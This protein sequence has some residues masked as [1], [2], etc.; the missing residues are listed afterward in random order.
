[1]IRKYTKSHRR[2]M[3]PIPKTECFN[4]EGILGREFGMVLTQ[5]GVG[6]LK[7]IV[8]IHCAWLCC[9]VLV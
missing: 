6:D 4:R 9:S 7:Q 2:S 3:P 1:M 5:L 8:T